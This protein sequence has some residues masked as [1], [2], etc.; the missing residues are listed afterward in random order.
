M[1]KPGMGKPDMGKPG[2]GKQGD[3]ARIFNELTRKH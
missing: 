1:G 2:M 3:F